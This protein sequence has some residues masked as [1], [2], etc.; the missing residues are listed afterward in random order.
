MHLE[1][2]LRIAYPDRYGDQ[3]RRR[4][5]RDGVYVDTISGAWRIED[6]TIADVI[7]AY[8]D[9]LDQDAFV[10]GKN[11]SKNRKNKRK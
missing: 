5:T 2:A 1:D 6:G 8:A 3:G 11:F 7:E 9:W 10:W 4:R